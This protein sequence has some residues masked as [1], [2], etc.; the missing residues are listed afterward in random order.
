MSPDFLHLFVILLLAHLLGDF[1]LQFRWIRQQKK[2]WPARLIHSAV[3]AVLAYVLIAN[4]NL[5]LVAAITGV[6]HYL[7]DWGLFSEK[8]KIFR[9][10]IVDQA[11]HL[12]VIGGVTAYATAQS[13]S[14]PVWFAL[15]PAIAWDL[16]VVLNAVI[17]L[18]PL[19]GNL[20]GGFMAPFQGQ[21]D[22]HYSKLTHSN[23]T[24]GKSPVKGLEDGGKVIGYLE[25]L[26]ILVFIVANQYA[27]IGFLIAAKSVFRFGEF[28]ES[29]N[30][31]EAEYI[32]IG[33][34]ASFLYAIVI[35]QAARWL[36]G[37]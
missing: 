34:F 7:I 24:N 35:S 13:A 28:K 12:I 26:L 15:Q 17:L 37:L 19:G 22:N 25:R 36:L 11:L 20:I 32:I 4:W 29:E 31:M 27:G 1:P 14:L 33:T 8:S 16:V 5:W 18:I 21:L 30:R 10:Q 23:S 6:S 2:H 9:G 3:H